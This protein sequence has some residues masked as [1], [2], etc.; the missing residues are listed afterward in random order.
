MDDLT[1]SYPRCKSKGFTFSN[2]HS[3]KKHLVKQEETNLFFTG[4]RRRISETSSSS[5]SLDCLDESAL[6]TTCVCGCVSRDK[7]NY[8]RHVSKCPIVPPSLENRKLFNLRTLR[9]REDSEL[10]ELSKA[11]A[12]LT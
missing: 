1:C 10:E 9:I 6:I 2:I 7:F 8:N 12:P 3:Y 5:S 11:F 4:K